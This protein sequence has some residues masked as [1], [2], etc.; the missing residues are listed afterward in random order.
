MFFLGVEEE[1]EIE[2][3]GLDPEVEKGKDV[4]VLREK[5]DMSSEVP[6]AAA[7][8]MEEIRGAGWFLTSSL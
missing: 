3:I 8:E 6:K 4:R 5:K 1:E 7:E 2:W